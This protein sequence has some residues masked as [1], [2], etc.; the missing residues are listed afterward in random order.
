MSE[1]FISYARSTAKEAGRVAESLRSQG[2][3][4]WRD[5]D[6]PAHR[7]YADVIEERL[8]AATAVVV[9][10]SAEAA[11]SEWVQSEADLARQNHKLVQLTVDGSHLPMPF[12]RIHCAD[13]SGWAGDLENAGW[14]KVVS[15]I[16]DLCR[17]APA[18]A[19][20]ARAP[21]HK[22]SL[23]EPLLAV[24]AFD[25]LSGDT[26]MA[27]FSD[28]VS[29][30]IL[31]TVAQGADLRVIGRS[32]SFQF[33]GRDKA[34][35]HV[36]AALNTTHV[37]DGSV[38][39][40]GSKVRIAA[41]L[42]EC[43]HETTIWS[44]RFERE[45]S[46]VFALQD[47][48]AAAVAAALRV[49]FA[50][51]APAESIDPAAYNLYLK[52]RELWN[53]DIEAEGHRTAIGLL[54]QATALAPKF[55]RAWEFLATVRGEV[56]TF[57]LPDASFAALRAQI[58]TAAQTA[59]RLD[60]SLGGAHQALGQL[61]AKGRFVEREAYHSKALSVSPKEP[62]VLLDASLFFCEL[63]R[64]AESLELIVQAY[65]LDPMR[66][67]VANWYGNMLDTVGRFDDARVFW[68]HAC[69]LWPANPLIAMNAI[70]AAASRGDW[71]R[72]DELVAHASEAGLNTRTVRGSIAYGLQV[73]DP[74][75]EVRARA[76]ARARN[77]L[78]QVGAL[79]AL[80]I[81]NLYKLGLTDEAFDLIDQASFAYMFDPEQ[82]SFNGPLT[83]ATLFNAVYNSAMMRDVRFVRLCAKLGLC[84]YWLATGK[85]PDCADQVPYDFRAEAARLAVAES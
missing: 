8:R 33:R 6:L 16:D 62:T 30:E 66:P 17:I 80:E 77:R 79:R 32:S 45:L 48:I 75:P 56:L 9:V 23:A 25:N 83:T 61:E 20:P 37:L 31:Q 63:G 49:A 40:S 57:D 72:F 39:R 60:P 64:A 78:A 14:R 65:Q 12:D 21:E 35:S 22:A 59:L 54:E 81:S 19:A 82:R 51:A 28:G 76:L 42:V 47:E 46:D 69:D 2:Y 3:K 5:E 1:I 4:V 26:E 27:Y 24:L 70:N 50:P 71:G 74:T 68:K 15:S 53:E 73:R 10:W 67:R 41:S 85:W 34:A 38:R 52:A 43:V 36:A 84:E 44:G 29:E 13:L 18:E 7:S 11:K 58:V 55:A